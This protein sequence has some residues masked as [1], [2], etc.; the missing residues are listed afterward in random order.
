MATRTLN[1]ALWDYR[2]R[3]GQHHRAYFGATIDTDDLSTADAQRAERL[4]IFAVETEPEP[5]KRSARKVEWIDYAVSQGN[6]PR[7]GPKR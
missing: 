3:D 2:D 4:E 5:P 1:V 6:G 7:L